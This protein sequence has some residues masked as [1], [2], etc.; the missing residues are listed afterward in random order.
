MTI[1][2]PLP[3]KFIIEFESPKA[4]LEAIQRLLNMLIY[5]E[6]TRRS[7]A[8]QE[9]VDELAREVNKSWWAENK[10]RFLNA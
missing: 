3:G 8:T 1:Q 9:Q 5:E 7:R 4:N 6:A 2:Q 10:H